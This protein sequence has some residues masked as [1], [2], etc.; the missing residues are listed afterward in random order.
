MQAPTWWA[1]PRYERPE[2]A[3]SSSSIVAEHRRWVLA[4]IA[5][6]GGAARKAMIHAV[7]AIGMYAQREDGAPWVTYS[8]VARGADVSERAARRGLREACRVLGA[9][10]DRRGVVHLKPEA[11][12]AAFDVAHQVVA[13]GGMHEPAVSVP[14]TGPA[15]QLDPVAGE[16]G[17]CRCPCGNHA[18]DDESPSGLFDLARRRLTCLATGA[19]LLLSQAGAGWVAQRIDYENSPDEAVSRAISNGYPS[20][21]AGARGLT[22]AGLPGSGPTIARGVRVGELH[23]SGSSSWRRDRWV[24]LDWVSYLRQCEDQD[25]DQAWKRAAW[26]G[27]PDQLIALETPKPGGGSVGTSRVLF[28]FDDL[29]WRPVDWRE[30]APRIEAVV[31]GS[32]LLEHALSVVTTSAHGVQ[33][34]AEL[35]EHR[36]DS[37]S[38]FR[39]QEVRAELERIAGELLEVLDRGG[40]ADP[41]AWSP[42]RFGRLPGY[43]L[44]DGLV[45]RA[46]LVA[47]LWDGVLAAI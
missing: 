20:A 43:R 40:R 14:T 19:V 42:G 5:E 28:D 16:L 11:L 32:P 45:E 24:D 36:W 7:W 44:R 31:R 21:R 46:T 8:Y 33:V 37:R 9:S 30:L 18:H 10:R 35:V 34:V 2:L 1:T 26:S 25:P 29:G 23:G 6:L 22:Q 38:F 47:A 15:F 17:R 3:P 12:A 27:Y 4:S 39:D 13:E 41:S